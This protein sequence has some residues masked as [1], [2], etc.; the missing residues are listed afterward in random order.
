M[1]AEI[2]RH[3]AANGGVMPDSGCNAPRPVLPNNCPILVRQ[4]WPVV[5]AAAVVVGLLP[6]RLV[7]LVRGRRA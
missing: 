1:Q 4:R 6:C 3:V 2:D 7:R 5:L